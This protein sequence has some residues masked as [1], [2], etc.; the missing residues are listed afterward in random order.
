MVER[1]QLDWEVDG[2]DLIMK[3]SIRIPIPEFLRLAEKVAAV[4]RP[5]RT[6]NPDPAAIEIL[7][8][9]D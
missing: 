6:I 9:N 3:Q 2:E 1:I 5:V 8:D 7:N 4:Y